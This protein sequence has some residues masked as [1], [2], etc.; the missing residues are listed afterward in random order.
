M[1]SLDQ[2]TLAVLRPV[3]VILAAAIGAGPAMSGALLSVPVEL[4]AEGT[5]LTVQHSCSDGTDL[6]VQYINGAANTLALIPLTGEDLIFVNVISGSGARYVSG[7]RTWWAKGDEATLSD[8]T[9]EA[10]PI[11]CAAKGATTSQ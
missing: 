3:I 9:G 6:S 11:T 5:I 2:T 1:K 8:E 4:G 7:T 10:E